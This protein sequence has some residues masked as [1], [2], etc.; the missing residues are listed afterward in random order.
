MAILSSVVAALN[1]TAPG[2]ISYRAMCSDDHR[3]GHFVRSNS[4]PYYGMRISK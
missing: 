3:S 1:F 4:V 2:R